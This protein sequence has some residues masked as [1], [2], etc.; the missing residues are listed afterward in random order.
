MRRHLVL[1]SVWAAACTAQALADSWVFRPSYY[2]HDPATGQ[3]VNQYHAEKAPYARIDPTY[4]QSMY[5]HVQTALSVGGSGDYQHWVET[6]G[7]GEYLRPYE[8]WLY[9][10]REGAT[11]FGPWG[12]PR[13]PWSLPYSPWFNPYGWALPYGLPYPYGPPTVYRLPA[14]VPYPPAAPWAPWPY[15]GS[16]PAAPEPVPTPPPVPQVQ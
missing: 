11:P 7:R 10:F 4:Q 2:S 16:S 1:A 12:N 3:R 5:R 14:P 15:P 6:W 9:P 13:G 8:E